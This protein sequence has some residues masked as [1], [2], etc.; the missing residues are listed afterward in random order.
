[1]GTSIRILKGSPAFFVLSRNFV[2]CYALF[3]FFWV[4]LLDFQYFWVD[5]GHFWADFKQFL[6]TFISRFSENGSDAQ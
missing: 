6:T 3:G 1:M 5:F 2:V 4:N